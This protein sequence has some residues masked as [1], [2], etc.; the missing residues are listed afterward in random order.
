MNP[1][2][3]LLYDALEHDAE[4]CKISIEMCVRERERKTFSRRNSHNSALSKQKSSLI[5][6][7]ITTM[8]ISVTYC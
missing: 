2:V 8:T 4:F 7:N 1:A 3:S 5:A 6:L